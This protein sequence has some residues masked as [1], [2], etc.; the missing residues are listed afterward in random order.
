MLSLRA[1]SPHSL[2]KL[3]DR[4]EIGFSMLYHYNEELQRVSMCAQIEGSARPLY[5]EKKPWEN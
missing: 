3:I 5:A 4:V 1:G 2:A